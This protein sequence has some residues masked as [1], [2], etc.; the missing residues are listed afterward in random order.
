MLI[1][2]IVTKNPADRVKK[3]KN[4]EEKN[5]VYLNEDEIAEIRE[6]IY[7][8]VNTEDNQFVNR[9]LAI[10]NIGVTTGL[11]VSAIININVDDIDFKEMSMQVIE[12]GNKYRTVF[13][14]E[15][16]MDSIK[17]WLVDRDKILKDN[18][19]TSDALFLNSH[20]ERITISCIRYMLKRETSFLGKNITPHKLRSTCAMNLYDKTHDIY[21][22]QQQLG[23]KN[24]QNT[25]IYA[26]A[27]EKRRRDATNILDNI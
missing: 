14:G 15:N 27:S 4:N 16:T 20:G 3:I 23:H 18:N 7:Y 6:N 10:F 12:K 13:I 26:K 9:N 1:N 19:K 2:D 25:E 22:V 8:C 24:I 21:L 5:V 17:K 11:R